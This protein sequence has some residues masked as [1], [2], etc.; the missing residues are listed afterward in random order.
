MKEEGNNEVQT[1]GPLLSLNNRSHE[2]VV[3]VQNC[4]LPVVDW[5]TEVQSTPFTSGRQAQPGNAVLRSSSGHL[6]P[7][8]D[9]ARDWPR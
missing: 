9:Q 7:K 8:L 3:A 1:S 6:L 5:T 4:S 2:V